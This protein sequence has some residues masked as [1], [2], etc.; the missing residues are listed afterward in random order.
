MKV[1]VIILAL[2]TAFAIHKA[3]KYYI[4]SL[5]LA[6]WMAE[7]EYAPPEKEDVKRLAAWAV[8]KL[9]KKD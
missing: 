3:Y 8:Q 1:S 4:I 6:A 2:V 9:F 7:N 5:V